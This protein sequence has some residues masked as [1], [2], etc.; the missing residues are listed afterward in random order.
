MCSRDLFHSSINTVRFSRCRFPF[1]FENI[2][3][4]PTASR[5]QQVIPLLLQEIGR[6]VVEKPSSS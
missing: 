3:T 4:S 6:L 1:D 5:S 2:P